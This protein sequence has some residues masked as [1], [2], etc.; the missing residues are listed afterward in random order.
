M[1]TPTLY[2]F[3]DQYV[4]FHCSGCE[5]QTSLVGEVEEVGTSGVTVRRTGGYVRR[6]TCQVGV[7]GGF[8]SAV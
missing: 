8:A 7:R 4:R 3:A 1:T 5:H 6:R 2:M